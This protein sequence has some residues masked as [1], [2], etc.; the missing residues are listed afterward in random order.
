MTLPILDASPLLV[1]GGGLDAALQGSR[2]GQKVWARKIK[3]KGEELPYPWGELIGL[4]E[5]DCSSDPW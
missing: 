1:I 4:K 2:E 5:A 3:S